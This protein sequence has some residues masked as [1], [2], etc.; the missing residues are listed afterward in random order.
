MR[1]SGTLNCQG[2]KL[3]L[4]SATESLHNS[5]LK[6]EVRVLGAVMVTWQDTSVGLSF[7]FFLLCS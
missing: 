4:G 5:L 3:K 1:Q 7:F 2:R 6:E